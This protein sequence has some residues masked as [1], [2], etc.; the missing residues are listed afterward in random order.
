MGESLD[1]SFKYVEFG[2]EN[3]YRWLNLNQSSLYHYTAILVPPHLHLPCSDNPKV[4]KH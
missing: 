3:V 1:T 2:G 4:L